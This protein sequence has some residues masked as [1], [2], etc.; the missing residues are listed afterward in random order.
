M[1]MI[2]IKS[3][4]VRLCPNTI[5]LAVGDKA[6]VM[7]HIS[8]KHLFHFSEPDANADVV[9]GLDDFGS[10]CNVIF[11]K[12]RPKK[13]DARVIL[14]SSWSSSAVLSLIPTALDSLAPE[15]KSAFLK[16]CI[17]NLIS[18]ATLLWNEQRDEAMTLNRSVG[19]LVSPLK[20]V[21]E[22]CPDKAGQDVARQAISQAKAAPNKEAAIAIIEAAKSNELLK[23]FWE[24]ESD[25]EAGTAPTARC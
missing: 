2:R 8:E 18:E 5:Y 16:V 4:S 19:L 9:E 14:L 7:K 23:P 15:K 1:N 11:L 22:K 10:K 20:K 24:D 25:T 17:K 6:E 21:V 13:E 3:I 12:D